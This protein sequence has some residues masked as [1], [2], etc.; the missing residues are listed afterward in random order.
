MEEWAV[1]K[2]ENKSSEKTKRSYEFT[3]A[4]WGLAV[5]MLLMAYLQVRWFGWSVFYGIGVFLGVMGYG[6]GV[7][8][9]ARARGSQPGREALLWLGILG[10]CSFSAA[11]VYNPSLAWFQM[12]FLRL[13]YLY[14]PA[15]VFGS[16]AAGK[17]SGYVVHDAVWNFLLVPVKYLGAQFKILRQRMGKHH[18]SRQLGYGILGC[19]A[20][21]PVLFLV[22][23]LLALADDTFARVLNNGFQKITGCWAGYAAD[24][25]LSLPLGAYLYGQLYGCACHRPEDYPSE[26]K[27]KKANQKQAV[28]PFAAMCP[29]LVGIVLLYLLFLVIQ[30][31]YYM[32]GLQGQLP[33]GFTY[34]QYA[35]QG[36]FELLAVSVLNLGIIAGARRFLRKNPD[37]TGRGAGLLRW[38]TL[39]LC[40][41]TLLLILTAMAKMYLY[42][43]TYGLTPRRV[44]PSLFMLFL[45]AVF[46]LIGISQ[47]RPVPVMRISVLLFATGFS[48]LTLCGMD[49]RIASYNLE[50]YAEGSLEDF[51][52]ITLLEGDL[53]SIPAMY[54]VWMET[55]DAELKEQ[56]EETAG[57]IRSRQDYTYFVNGEWSSANYGRNK[58]K[59]YLER[60]CG[61]PEGQNLSQP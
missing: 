26:E 53:A 44:I 57:Q 8:A 46:L 4:D 21:F 61:V 3:G 49:G 56:I 20:A 10:V 47:F 52:R 31:S 28:I 48:V 41:L 17:T 12:L 30:G 22:V 9:Y 29:L 35:R 39:A 36:F 16:L 45:A 42:I 40:V 43:Q 32:G 19:L 33:D 7:L 50:R 23:G 24:G 15:V 14:F 55:E 54:R 38:H 51:P 18:L 60:M 37:G 59:E 1:Q 13:S 25:L 2:K 11:G 6:L 34:S 58:A 27:L 5:G